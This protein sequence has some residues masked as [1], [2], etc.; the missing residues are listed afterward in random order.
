M[1]MT[2]TPSRLTSL[3]HV[4]LLTLLTC[5]P[6]VTAFAALR[7]ATVTISAREQTQIGATFWEA[8]RAHLRIGG[9]VQLLW[10]AAVVLGAVDVVA[11]LFAVSS[12]RSVVAAAGAMVIVTAIA[13]LPY[14][15]LSCR[16]QLPLRQVARDAVARAG[17]RPAVA[18]A[19]SVLTVATVAMAV[20]LPY[21]LPLY[22]GGWALI[23]TAVV[24]RGDDAVSQ[25]SGVRAGVAA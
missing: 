15:V 17:F 8:F 20:V 23:C 21:G 11:A 9:K 12:L 13:L 16:P 14:L 5:L 22:L 19:L 7:A 6:V 18:V 1:N 2:F 24:Q 4:G 3:L 25:R 10:T